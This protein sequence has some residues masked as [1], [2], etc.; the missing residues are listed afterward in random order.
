MRESFYYYILYSLIAGWNSVEDKLENFGKVKGLKLK[1]FGV[2]KSKML[3]CDEVS[4]E[5]L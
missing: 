2:V 5:N 1:Y 3:F 4:G